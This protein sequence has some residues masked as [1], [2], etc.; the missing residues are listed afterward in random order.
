MAPAARQ[1]EKI[2]VLA[3]ALRGGNGFYRE[4]LGGVNVA[5][6]ETFVATCPFTDKAML[7][8]DREQ[9]PPWGTNLTCP[10]ENYSRFVQTSGTTGVPMAWLDT[11]E[12]WAAMLRCW[13]VVYEKAGVVPGTDRAFFAFSFGPFLGFWTAFEAAASME[14][15]AI[16][17]GGMSSAA[18]LE[19]MR[20][21]AVTVLCCT[22]TYALRLGE[23]RAA[24]PPAGRPSRVR[25]ILVA[26][27]PGGSI[28]ATR[29]RLERLWPGARV[30]DHHG[31]TEVG[32]VS[33][34]DPQAPGRLCVIEDAYLAEILDRD[35]LTE[36]PEGQC[37]ELV[38]TTLER[39][40]CPL[41]RYRTGDLVRKGRGSDGALAL[42]GGIL[43]R[44]DDMVVVRGVNL[45]P[46]AV[47]D[48]VR[49]FEDVTEF[50]V[51]E[52]TRNQ[53]AEVTVQVELADAAAGD[54]S[55]AT[56][57][58]LEAALRDAFGL[59]IPVV[60]VASGALPRFEFKARRW[61][62]ET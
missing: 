4:R 44:I 55:P 43:G 11:R 40:A 21:Y 51:V 30:F 35:T 37:G 19:A 24:L 45:Y 59:R 2:R 39:V 27:E 53:M 47:E 13:N 58:A 22:P 36:V 50:R 6:L 48:V 9:H 16:P 42:D 8:A 38:L 5:S 49:R 54:S 3:D 10:L 41:L 60:T 12:S 23:M 28:P 52:R 25:L 61:I 32:P 34:Q 7:A 26:G 17:S 57:N 15:M 1:L 18:R 31:L 33:Y 56:V 20:R 14:L 29:Q 46:G 62:R